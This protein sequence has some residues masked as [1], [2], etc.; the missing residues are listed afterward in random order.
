MLSVFGKWVPLVAYNYCPILISSLRYFVNFGVPGEIRTW[1][2][3]PES[4]TLHSKPL[5]LSSMASYIQHGQSSARKWGNRQTA[6]KG[7]T[8]DNDISLVD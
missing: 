1:S 7:K 4:A 5:L 6:S 2:M 8:A 3:N